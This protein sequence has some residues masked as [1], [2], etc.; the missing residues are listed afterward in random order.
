MCAFLDKTMPDKPFPSGNAPP[1]FTK[2][3][4]EKRAPQI[5]QARANVA[6]TLGVMAAAV[7]AMWLAYVRLKQ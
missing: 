7:V 6:K 3:I 1:A 5:R 4:A 2:R